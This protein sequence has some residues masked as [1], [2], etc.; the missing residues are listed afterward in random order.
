MQYAFAHPVLPERM[1]EYRK[2]ASDMEGMRAPE[3]QRFLREH[4]IHRERVFLQRLPS[5]GG[6]VTVDWD[7]DD[8]HRALELTAGNSEHGRFIRD[9]ILIRCAGI[10]EEAFA[11]DLAMLPNELV[12][13]VTALPG[14]ALTS[15]AFTMPILPDRV[16]DWLDWAAEL[17]SGTER[18][19]YQEYLRNAGVHAE[20]VFFQQ[21]TQPGAKAMAVFV[22]ECDD[23]VASLSYLG[24]SQDDVAVKMRAMIEDMCGIDLLT[25]PDPDIELVAAGHVRRADMKPHPNAELI[26]AGYRAFSTMDVAGL[27]RLIH[28]KCVWRSYTPGAL[29]G[30]YFGFD[31]IVAYFAHIM[32]ETEA[33]RLDIEEVY[34]GDHGGVAITRMEATRNGR[35]MRTRTGVR[36]TIADGE[37]IEADAFNLTPPKE[38]EDFWR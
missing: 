31:E 24:H 10:P 13:S 5:G 11:N 26:R 9:E 20:T 3:H 19:D 34:A 28:P 25:A 7:C 6:M 22:R 2:I 18:L 8:V 12:G 15:V 36:F 30:S 14:E 35:T 23:P 21:A 16:E 17:D 29:G 27:A 33:Y 4:G 37:V 1:E 32:D 38:L